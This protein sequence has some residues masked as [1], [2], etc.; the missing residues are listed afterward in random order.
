MH[1]GTAPMPESRDPPSLQELVKAYGTHD[2][3]PQKAWATFHADMAAWKDKVRYG[4]F[5]PLRFPP[6][7]GR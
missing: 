2:K 6:G 4:E 1:D 7:Q 5:E 3:I